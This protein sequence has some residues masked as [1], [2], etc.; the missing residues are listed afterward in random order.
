MKTTNESVLLTY[1]ISEFRL[2]NEAGGVSRDERNHGRIHLRQDV[3][4]ATGKPQ[5]RWGG[6]ERKICFTG[7]WQM[8]SFFRYG[9]NSLELLMVKHCDDENVK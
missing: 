7:T 9:Q 1:V 3:S 4:G 8:I 2:Q 6:V 5:I